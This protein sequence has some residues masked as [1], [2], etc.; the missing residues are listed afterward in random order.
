MRKK[1]KARTAVT[2][3]AIAT[4]NPHSV[5]TPSTTSTRLRA[6][7]VAFNPMRSERKIIAKTVANEIR[8]RARRV[9]T[10]RFSPKRGIV[11]I[12][13]T[14]VEQMSS[15]TNYLDR[16]SILIPCSADWELM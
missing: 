13:D 10:L 9:S 1:L 14:G 6:T 5:A 11:Y 8:Y 7:V 15:Q 16:L 2:D 12:E 4:A 3:V